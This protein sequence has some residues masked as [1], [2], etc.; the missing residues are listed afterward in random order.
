MKR[1]RWCGLALALLLS[2]PSL[3]VAAQEITGHINGRV[4]DEKGDPIPGVRI[5]LTSPV[6][7]GER[8]TTTSELGTYAFTA[9]PPGM[10]TLRFEA[11]G[12]KT[13]VRTD[14]EVRVGF[15]AT[16]NV[17]LEVA[18]IEESVTVVGETPILDVSATQVGVNYTERLLKEL[19]TARDIWVT[20]AMTPGITMI[21]RHDVGGATA[22]TQTAYRNY[23]ARG[24]N[25]P[26]IDGVITTEGSEAAG[27][28]YDYGA[29]TEIQIVAAS[30]SAEVPVP[31]T[32]INTVIKTG[33]NEFHGDFY[34]DYEREG[35][36]SDNVKGRSY[37]LPTGVTLPLV[38]M[39]IPRAAKIKLYNDWN[40]NV[41]GRIIRDK[42]WWFVSWRDQR[43]HAG[44]LGWVS[45]KGE[46]DLFPTRLQ[47][48]TIKLTYQLTPKNTI[49]WFTQ[50]GR[51]IQPYRNWLAPAP[52]RFTSPDA[53][54]NQDSWSWAGKVQW[55]STLTP[56]V[57][58]DVNVGHMGYDW[59]QRPYSNRPRYRDFN[60][61]LFQ[62]GP[63]EEA[64][65]LNEQR[66]WQWQGHLSWRVDHFLRGS[67]NLKFGIWRL[68]EA[69][70]RTEYGVWA[71]NAQDVVYWF[72]GCT[73]VAPNLSCD[74]A[75]PVEIRQYN[76]PWFF[77]HGLHTTSFFVQDGWEVGRHVRLNLGMR[78]DS[79]R[80]FWRDQKQPAGRFQ[81][82]YVIPKNDDVL[83]WTS[84]APRLGFVWDLFG[85]TK[86]V[87]RL[88]YGRYYFNPST[89][90]VA[91]V[92]PSTR[93]YKRFAWN[94]KNGDR[95]WS[96]DELTLIAVVGG[97]NRT[98]DPNVKHPYT[99]EFTA[100]IE[101]ELMR[102]LSVR[103]N[104]VR[105]FEKN[106][107]TS[108]PLHAPFSAYAV[109]VTVT[110]PGRDGR[111]GTSDDRQI[112]LYDIDDA[113]RLA[114]PRFLIATNPAY[115][116][117][118]VAYEVD[119]FKRMSRR[120]MLITGY[121][122]QK[123]NGWTEGINDQYPTDPNALLNSARHT[124]EWLYKLQGIYELPWGFQFSTVFKHQRGDPYRRTFAA[125]L[126]KLRTVTVAAEGFD[127]GLRL[128]NVNLWDI[129]IMKRFRIAERHR[130]DVMGDLFNVINAN[131][132]LA[133]VTTTGPRFGQPTRILGPRVFRLAFRYSF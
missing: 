116:N 55:V 4:T 3:S 106:R 34:V 107:W 20:L 69:R 130:V 50:G 85:D 64:F 74:T 2:V 120:W 46:K 26:N 132:P 78:V 58:L 28:Y 29:F 115:Q 98:L 37:R 91:A 97:Q 59:P 11:S 41:G 31:G 52:D 84:V 51:K 42:L 114:N 68:F 103:F 18:A 66:R 15:T 121:T 35:W 62:I 44:A 77:H 71:G 83:S 112:T 122:I 125:T 124:W 24:Q 118:F 72:R 96:P 6:L 7:I 10:Y 101:R 61:L 76:Y 12:F 1:K 133:V 45:P 100:G 9:L 14:I 19:P 93:T 105:K 5:T 86:T 27:F 117:N 49:H 131:T 75:T 53:V 8:V 39:G 104:V 32:F 21:G 60:N 127:S 33:T 38:D 88:S 87:I 47:N 65:F 40:A 73:G 90:I 43:N 23:G 110:D 89:D 30:N 102:D 82:E 94:D 13:L 57:L 123:L 67:H 80:N 56:K 126:P 95:D 17:K 99:D 70:R 22:G 36:N 48:Q 92:N 113:A 108:F 63:P 81:Q 54:A 128:P 25:W 16:I 79:Y 109:P 129:R 119:V 111:V